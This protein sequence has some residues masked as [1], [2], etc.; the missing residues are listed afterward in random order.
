LT[1][2]ISLESEAL[3]TEP[4]AKS[5]TTQIRIHHKSFKLYL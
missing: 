5:G 2:D 1:G 3:P 4:T